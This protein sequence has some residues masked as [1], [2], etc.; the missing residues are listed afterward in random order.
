VK[1]LQ[2]T[3]LALVALAS[4][5]ACSSDDLTEIVV[6]VESDLSVPGELDAV[7]VDIMAGGQSSSS[8]G[9]LTGAG[10]LPL[11]RVLNL[12]HSGG[13]LGPV[14]VRAVGRLGGAEVVSREAR[15]FFI[16]GRTV[17][18]RLELLRSCVGSTC[19]ADETCAAGGCRPVDVDPSELS[20]WT[21]TTDRPD[22]GGEC[23]GVAERCNDLDDDCDGMIDEDFNL[24]TDPLNCGGCNVRCPAPANSTASCDGGRCGGSCDAGFADCD[25][26]PA[27]GC[28]ADLGSP[29]TCGACDTPCV[30]PNAAADCMAGVCSFSSCDAGFGDCDM[31]TANGCEV[32]L[33]SLTDCGACGAAC[34][35]AASTPTCGTGTCAV[36]S[37]DAGFGDCD[38]DTATGCE[39]ALTSLTDCGACGTACTRASATA[40]C[41]TGVCAIDTCDPGFD[42][43]DATD[44]NGCEVDLSSDDA[45]CSACGMAC[46]GTTACHAGVCRPAAHII[47]TTAGTA[48]TCGLRVSGAVMCWGLNAEGQLGDGTTTR[49]DT[50][51]AVS[52]LTDAVQISAGDQ[53]A[54][55]V[56]ANG[57]VVCWGDNF[58]G[59]LG[60]GSRTDRDTPV[61]VMGITDAIWVTAGGEHSCAVRSG[62]GVS[63]WG[64]NRDRQLGDGTGTR[65][66][67]PVATM[68]ITDAVRITAGGAHTCAL[69]SG[70]S[71]SCWG[72]NDSGQLGDGSTTTRDTAVAV[73]GLADATDLSAGLLHTC[74]VRS[75]GGVVCWGDNGNGRLG[76]AGGDRST[77][78]AVAGTGAVSHVAA[79]DA[80]TCARRTTGAVRCWGSD[81]QGQLGNGGAGGGPTPVDV[82]G[83]SDADEVSAGGPHSCVARATGGVDC[84]GRGLNG[85]L[86]DGAATSSTTP[87]ST[88]GLP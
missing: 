56:R 53:H 54:C 85:Q 28:E 20:D 50:P 79:G 37:C 63:C 52:G 33:T 72:L 41:G 88:S 60:D 26:D 77:P 51:V 31:D 66:S 82:S 7:R 14:E 73:T 24:G 81:A 29:A 58:Q 8:T 67:T 17:V 47:Q 6:V 70:G 39:V 23:P 15:V 49:R 65:R 78:T 2:A 62:G 16:E 74:A 18:L 69:R 68:G 9:D 71:V 45:H 75:G 10:A 43:C 12:L 84:W 59:Q 32:A 83:L 61:A 34:A 87:V 3:T 38:M 44:A 46:A 30:I 11:P 64:R 55:A 40:T 25:G 13:P 19:G 27:T 86:G 57:R 36:E 80:H 35:P 21:G 4:A 1:R 5:A 22:A 48:F 42:D 76:T